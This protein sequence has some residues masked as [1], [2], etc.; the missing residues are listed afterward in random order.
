MEKKKHRRSLPTPLSAKS[1]S[2]HRKVSATPTRHRSNTSAVHSSDQYAKN[3]SPPRKE[4]LRSSRRSKTPV[5]KLSNSHKESRREEK[6]SVESSKTPVKK[7]SNSHKESRHEEKLSV[8]S[9]SEH[10][11]GSTR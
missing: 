2:L 10:R 11:I 4:R 1:V 9:S 3:D 8:E 7:L 5:K 6:L